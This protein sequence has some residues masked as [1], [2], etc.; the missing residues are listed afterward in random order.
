MV[1]VDVMCG[2]S[3]FQALTSDDDARYLA[4]LLRDAVEAGVFFDG[5]DPVVDVLLPLAL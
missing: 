1:V 4:W 2:Q 5:L 3:S